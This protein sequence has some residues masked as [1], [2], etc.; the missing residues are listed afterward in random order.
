MVW[1]KCLVSQRE[2][3]KTIF[4][5]FPSS[6]TKIASSSLAVL[7]TTEYSLATFEYVEVADF[8]PEQVKIFAQNWFTALAE[9][10]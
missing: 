2:M 9:D 10:A 1:M 3:S 8:N 7:Q 5:S 6:I 4:M